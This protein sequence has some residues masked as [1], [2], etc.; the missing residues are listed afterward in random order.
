MLRIL[1]E[2]ISG[3][4]AAMMS[5]TISERVT[6]GTGLLERRVHCWIRHHSEGKAPSTVLMGVYKRV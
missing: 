2:A 1:K 4:L 5:T 3:I 6:G